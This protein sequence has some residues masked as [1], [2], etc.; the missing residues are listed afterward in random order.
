MITIQ[1]NG[2]PKEIQQDCTVMQL[3]EQLALHHKR[4]AV[5]INREI[6]KRDA[7]EEHRIKDG[8]EIEVLQFVGGGS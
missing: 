8:D 4:V 1:L 2:K 7:Y 6:L 5:E 3:L